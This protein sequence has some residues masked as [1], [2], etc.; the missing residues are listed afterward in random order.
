MLINW[1]LGHKPQ[2]FCHGSEG[3]CGCLYQCCGLDELFWAH[4]F[5]F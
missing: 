2:Q 4:G 3:G 1:I 5:I